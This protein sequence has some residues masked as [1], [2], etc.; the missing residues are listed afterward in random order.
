MTGWTTRADVTRKLRRRWDSGELL[1]AYATGEALLPIEVSLRRPGPRDIATDLAAVREWANPWRVGNGLR[2][3]YQAVGG[4]IVGSN[5]LPRRV[6][7]D[8]WPQLWALLG[9]GGAVRRFL[10]LLD[11]TRAAAPALTDWMLG[12]PHDV[13]TLA[14]DW[15]KIVD[16]VRWIDA[17]AASGSYLRQVDVPGVDTKFIERHR[18]VLSRLLDRQLAEHRIDTDCPP[19]DF[20]GRYR[21]RRKPQYVRYR[22]LD[23]LRATAGFTELNVR[24]DEL[25]AAPPEA[26]TIVIVENETTYLALPPV[27]DAIAI[28]G[29][30]YALTRLNALSWLAD[31][32]VRYWGDIDTHGFAI[33]DRLRQRFPHAESLLMDRDTLL[34]HEGQWVREDSPTVTVLDHLRPAELDL[35]RD[36]VDDTFGHAVR[37]EQERVRYSVVE[38]TVRDR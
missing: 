26:T 33:L 6:W 14:D 15:V 12:K 8:E 13:L 9:V 29:G 1:A 34:S 27:P 19:A 25:A 38:S 11:H 21:F 22:W 20:I 31:R 30:G 28:F 32:R 4:R 35:Y 5:E 24:V 2:V 3:E 36:L 10:D 23:P 17:R 37:L 18:T 7:I 16:T